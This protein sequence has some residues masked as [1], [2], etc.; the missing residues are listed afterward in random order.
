M[1]ELRIF[2]GTSTPLSLQWRLRSG[3]MTESSR[4]G[5]AGKVFC[6]S[7]GVCTSTSALWRNVG[8]SYGAAITSLAAPRDPP[9]AGS[10]LPPPSLTSEAS[11]KQTQRRPG[12]E[13]CKQRA[14]HPSL[15]LQKPVPHYDAPHHRRF[16]QPSLFRREPGLM[17]SCSR[18]GSPDRRDLASHELDTRVTLASLCVVSIPPRRWF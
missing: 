1:G 17:L 8:L 12:S 6:R 4:L 16:V 11:I 13:K 7:C 2:L 15:D 5:S 18:P 9:R 10:S 14:S 3:K